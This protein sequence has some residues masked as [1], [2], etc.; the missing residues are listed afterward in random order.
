MPATMLPPAIALV[1]ST[2]D[3]MKTKLPPQKMA[4]L[5]SRMSAT[6]A[7]RREPCVIVAGGAI[8]AILADGR[9][10]RESRVRAR[11]ARAGTPASILCAHAE[12]ASRSSLEMPPRSSAES[13]CARSPS[14]RAMIETSGASAR[15]LSAS[16]STTPTRRTKASTDRPWLKRAE[17]PVGSTWLVPAA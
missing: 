3:L 16:I 4:T 1:R 9:G 14:S 17:P 8:A 6:S 13:A 12:S 2:A 11:P 5:K 15:A 10:R 7:M